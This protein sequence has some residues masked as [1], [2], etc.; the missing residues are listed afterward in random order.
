MPLERKSLNIFVTINYKKK[1]RTETI[2]HELSTLSLEGLY[3]FLYYFLNLDSLK[4]Q[5]FI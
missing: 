3:L 1:Q 4:M 2:L 5:Y